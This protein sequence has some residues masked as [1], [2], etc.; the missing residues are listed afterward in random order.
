MLNME[1]EKSIHWLM[2]AMIARR[3]RSAFPERGNAGLE[4]REFYAC[5]D[6]PKHLSPLIAVTPLRRSHTL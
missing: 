1:Q 4:S 5:F 6:V 2:E 3:R